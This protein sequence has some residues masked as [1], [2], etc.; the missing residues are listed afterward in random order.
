MEENNLFLIESCQDLRHDKEKEDI[1]HSLLKVTIGE[2][3]KKLETQDKDRGKEIENM[4]QEY[5][6]AVRHMRKLKE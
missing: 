6:V 1:R 2:E 3:K 5:E 4:R